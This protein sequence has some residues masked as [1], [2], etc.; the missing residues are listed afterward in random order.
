MDVVDAA[1]CDLWVL[2][3]RYPRCIP[4]SSCL[5]WTSRNPRN[6]G[7]GRPAQWLLAASGYQERD[8]R[9][10]LECNDGVAGHRGADEAVFVQRALRSVAICSG[11]RRV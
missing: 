7:L 11:S 6:R 1:A 5:C 2:A 8:T 9:P 3:R 4:A 10:L